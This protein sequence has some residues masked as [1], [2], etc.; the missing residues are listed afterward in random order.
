MGPFRLRF[1]RGPCRL[2]A[3]LIIMSVLHCNPGLSAEGRVVYRSGS[4]GLRPKGPPATQAT[5]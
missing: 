4:Q 1:G 3:L 2:L 5:G